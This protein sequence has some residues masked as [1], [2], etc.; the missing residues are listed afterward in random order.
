MGIAEI[1][2][3]ILLNLIPVFV[4]LFFYPFVRKNIWR[5]VYIRISICFVAFWVGYYILPIFLFASAGISAT[6][7]DLSNV[8]NPWVSAAGYYLTVFLNI[9][10]IFIRS[11]LFVLPFAFLFAPLVSVLIL[12]L[13]LRGEKGS[14]RDKIN[15][16]SYRFESSPLQRV[17]SRLMEKGWKEEKEMFKLM[18]VFL[19]ISLWLLTVILILSG[20]GVL[21]GGT[22]NVNISAF[23][24][25]LVAYLA[26]FLVAV[27][28]LYSSKLSFRGRSVGDRIR[29][30]VDRYLL[31]TGTILAL[32]SIIAFVLQF[33]Q[34]WTTIAYFVIHYAMMSVIFAV[35]LPLFEPFGS[36]LLIKTINF[37]RGSKTKTESRSFL[38][39]KILFSLLSGF[40]VASAAL[41]VDYIIVTGTSF[42]ESVKEASQ[43]YNQ[44][45]GSTCLINASPTFSDELLYIR[46]FMIFS[47][48]DILEI[49][50][51][52]LVLVWF[53]RQW[54]TQISV[55][56]L[57]VA[58]FSSL[59]YVISNSQVVGN[60]IPLP[61]P[62]YWVTAIPAV[63]TATNFSLPASRL[64]TLEVTGS[65]LDGGAIP[66]L[67]LSPLLLVLFLTYLIKYWK[68]P[69][70]V[71]KEVKEKTITEQSYSELTLMP[72]MDELR[73]SPEGFVFRYKGSKNLE[74]SLKNVAPEKRKDVKNLIEMLAKG[75]PMTLPALAKNTNMERKN[76]YD[77]LRYLIYS[78]LV[79]IGGMEFA[80]VTH[81][82]ALQSLYITTKDG[83]SILDYSFGSL[84]IEPAL[85][86][87]MLTAITSFVK[88]AT[89]SKEFLRTIE[90]GDVVLIVE[91]GTRIFATMIADQ[92]TPDVRIGLRK[93]V[94]EFE[95]RHASVLAK[96]TGAM[97]NVEKDKE[98][99]EKIFK[100]Y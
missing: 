57:S 46:L 51:V 99:A 76:L 15:E 38:N 25:D 69:L 8:Y 14:F 10:A 41:L 59:Y 34:S 31:T 72:S 84:T 40:A 2:T 90:H 65:A 54:N 83:L 96:W 60:L 9:A 36:L 20:Q 92:E 42:F 71:T 17:R 61:G 13:S 12:A 1:A 7:F 75:E 37:I 81:K 85:V 88:E 11:T 100:Q 16:L 70:Y 86:S 50:I 98:L 39:R 6:V 28:L 94:E 52:S 35:L 24:E 93:F 63:M 89:K 22:V 53:V 29:F 43:V 73:D 30:S 33:S 27:Y 87:G 3:S 5:R 18:I 66:F 56:I 19:P 47:F 21:A 49:L 4:I 80:S 58:F 26:S 23:V 95:R 67:S 79:E 68:A 74:E 55:T 62:Y 45:L 97:P 77:I 64:G 32:F 78:R 48:Q 44:L 82:P 91:Y